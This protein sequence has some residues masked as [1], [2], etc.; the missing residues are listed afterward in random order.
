MS[1]RVGIAGFGTVGSGVARLLLDSPAGLRLTHIFNRGA[2]R[3]KAAWVPADVRWTD[4]FDDLLAPEVDVIV[5]LVGGLDPAGDWVRRAIEAGKPVVTAN[6]QLIAERGRELLALAGRSDVPLRFEASVGG[7]IPVLRGVQEGLAA[8]RLHRVAGILNGTCNYVLSRMESAALTFEAA[9]AEAQR[10]GFA[11]ADPS[12]DVDGLDARAKLV[13]LMAVALRKWIKG[14]DVPCRSIVPIEAV[15]FAYARSLSS[16]IRQIS[17]AEIP[18]AGSDAVAAWVGPA[19]VPRDSPFARVDGSQNLIAVRGERGGETVFSGL[20]AGGD[21][22]A[23]A[24]VSD[25]LSIARGHGRPC[26]AAPDAAPGRVHADTTGRWYV[27]CTV[28]DRPGIIAALAQALA[29][30]GI[31]IDAVLQE[32]GHPKARLPFVLTLEPCLASALA[33]ALDQIARLPFNVTPPL[34]LPMVSAD[35]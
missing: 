17:F 15:D 24:V 6:K 10:K 2:E 19:L 5:E 34:A 11:E 29:S 18:A 25:I 21:P 4:R 32:P 1:F 35:A 8:D 7:G 22:T 20:G 28:E 31:N 9:L 16:T 3:K 27:R 30:R 14:A 12:A 13:I 33:G 23:V 26:V